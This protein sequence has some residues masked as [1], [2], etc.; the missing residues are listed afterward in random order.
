MAQVHFYGTGRRKNAIARVYLYP[1]EGQITVNG[2][3]PGEYFGRR[4]L[5]VIVNKPLELTGT[6]GRFDVMA[7]VH[8]GG[9]SGQAGAIKLG[10]ARA[11]I[12]ADPN[13]RKVLKS[14]GFLTRD[15]RMKER[16]KYGLKKAR[17]APQFS[18][19]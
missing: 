6:D 8:G 13:L 5:E 12:Q 15:P 18:K 3:K 4:S 16:R 11:L 14:A 19:R 1:G 7:K 2:K 17:R 9:T 10:I